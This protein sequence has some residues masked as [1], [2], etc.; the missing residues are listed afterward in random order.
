MSSNQGRFPTMR[1][2]LAM[3]KHETN[4]FSP[5]ET[6]IERFARRGDQPLRGQEAIDAYRGTGTVLGGF[7]AVAEESGAEIEVAIAAEAWPSGPVDDEAYRIMTDAICDAVERGGWDGILLD[8]HGAMVTESL[9][10]GE[11]SLLARVRALAPTT[12]IAV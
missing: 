9:E 8:L 2:L 6:K 1:L 3:M 10:D 12:P 4:T 7:M 5:V 11:G